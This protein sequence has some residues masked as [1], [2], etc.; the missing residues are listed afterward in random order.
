MLKGDN[1][2]LMRHFWRRAAIWREQLVAEIF[3]GR[4]HHEF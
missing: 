1:F 3:I 4:G 2:S